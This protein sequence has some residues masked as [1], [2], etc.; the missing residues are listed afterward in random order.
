LPRSW[1]PRPPDW[2]PWPS[3]HAGSGN[4]AQSDASGELAVR[5]GIKTGGCAERGRHCRT[6]A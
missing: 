6:G 5:R 1:P 2:P 4:Q 3:L